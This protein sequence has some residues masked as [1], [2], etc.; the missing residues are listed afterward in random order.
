MQQARIA[1]VVAAILLIAACGEAA[2]HTWAS[3]IPATPEPVVSLG[4]PPPLLG[5]VPPQAAEG[6]GPRA[7][8]SLNRDHAPSGAGADR[9]TPTLA[10][11]PGGEPIPPE[12]WIIGIAGHPPE[13]VSALARLYRAGGMSTL[14][15][16]TPYGAEPVAALVEWLGALCEMGFTPAEI[17]VDR[18]TVASGGACGWRLGR[19][20]TPGAGD[21]LARAGQGVPWEAPVVRF[22]CDGTL[23]S[24]PALDLALTAAALRVARVLGRSDDALDR[25]VER[26]VGPEQLIAD[27][28]GLLPRSERFWQKLRA[29]RRIAGPW[30]H[31]SF[32]VPDRRGTLERG[33]RGPRVTRLRR[34]LAAEGFLP[35]DAADGTV[36]DRA[37]RDAVLAYRDAYGLKHRSR[38]DREMAEMLS[39]EPEDLLADLGASMRA[40][41]LKGWDQNGTYV[42]VNIPAF[43][44]AL[45]VDGRRVASYRSVVGFSYR[46]PGGRTPEYDAVITD[47]ELNPTWTPSAD[48]VSHDLERQARRDRGFWSKNHFVRRGARWVQEPGPWNTLGQVV[49]AW[50][51]EE[52]IFL[53]GTNEPHYYDYQDRAL[54]RG[55]VRVEDIDDLAGR[56]LALT[57]Q[58]PEGGLEPLLRDVVERRIALHGAVPVQVIY[59]RIA[60][61]ATGATGLRPDVYGLDGGTRDPKQQIAP[62]VLALSEARKARRLATAD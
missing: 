6:E 39:R 32:P 17:G 52:N 10:P 35:L 23:P 11:I 28:D 40:G 62:L 20:G 15:A 46:E 53:H 59:D 57:R 42:L 30:S 25:L 24:K 12:A 48:V 50:P 4:D 31:G 61:T 22:L 9:S 58:T 60:V 5:E 27:L 37:T 38:V 54:S 41:L 36:F 8:T 2:P 21:P 49:V 16:G 1:I 18:V 13:I 19:Q 43:R 33:Q 7:E 55:C 26:W 29:F 45:Y 51:N 56:L 44:T 34:R 3:W 47:V 14:V